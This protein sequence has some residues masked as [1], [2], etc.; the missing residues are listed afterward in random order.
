M[1]VLIVCSGNSGNIAPF[2]IEQG[3]SL[4]MAGIQ[5]EYFSIK[6][7]GI[8]GY[9]KNL[10]PLKQRIAKHNPVLIHA[11]YGLSG[12]LAN[13]QRKVPVITTY[14][15]SDINVSKNFIFSKLSIALSKHNI[16]VS[17]KIANKANVKRNFSIIPCGV[18]LNVFYPMDKIACR[19]ALN[20]NSEDKIVL[21]SSSFDN[22]VKNYPLAKAAVNILKD[23]TKLQELKNLSRDKVNAYINACDVA[24]LSSFSEG[25]PQFIKEVL[26]CNCPIVSTD[27]GD[28]KWCIGDTEGCYLTSFEPKDVAEKIN[29]ALKFSN[30]K[31]RT[32]GRERITA[33]GLDAGTIA[34]RILEVYEKVLITN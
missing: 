6:G 15:G 27:V 16:F 18:D 26:A 2:I 11:H 23:K 9:L 21:F 20:L 32:K 22:Y 8:L 25:S 30:E 7:K 14:H 31:T 34:K 4:E 13:L 5:V 24:V 29:L 1:K 12:L 3:K 17:E 19:K 28:I 10:K 33:L